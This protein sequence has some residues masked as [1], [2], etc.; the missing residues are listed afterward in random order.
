MKK[1]CKM[2]CILHIFTLPHIKESSAA[3][4]KTTVYFKFVLLKLV[5][6]QKLRYLS[7][8]FCNERLI[9]SPKLKDKANDSQS[10]RLIW[11]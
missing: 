4:I 7:K 2:Y 8:K 9:F 1:L 11:N 10:C 5:F 3:K 6:I